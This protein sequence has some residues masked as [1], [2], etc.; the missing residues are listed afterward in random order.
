MQLYKL[1]L[2]YNLPLSQRFKKAFLPDA[3]CVKRCGVCLFRNGL[4]AEY[5]RYGK[6]FDCD[7][8]ELSEQSARFSRIQNRLLTGKGEKTDSILEFLEKLN[9][10][11]LNEYIKAIHFD[12]MKVPS[13]S[14]IL[15]TSK[16]YRGLKEMMESELDFLKATVL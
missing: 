1:W 7:E 13:L 12:E 14:F 4:A 6:A 5:C 16:K 15:P 3:F 2:I 10:F 11:D 8:K 9:S